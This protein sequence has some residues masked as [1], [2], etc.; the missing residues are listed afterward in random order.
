[1]WV[2][3]QVYLQDV[4]ASYVNPSILDSCEEYTGR[5]VIGLQSTLGAGNVVSRNATAV[6][7][8]GSV[9]VNVLVQAGDTQQTGG[10]AAVSRV[11][12]LPLEHSGECISSRVCAVKTWGK[13]NSLN[14]WR[15][16]STFMRSWQC[17]ACACAVRASVASTHLSLLLLLLLYVC[18]VCVR[19][20]S[21]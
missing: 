18:F 15:L 3:V 9:S 16:Q 7:V 2:S 8:T 10:F 4:S 20:C 12:F 21:W 14:E 6:A 19:C 1:M 17:C 11:G 13:L 5:Q